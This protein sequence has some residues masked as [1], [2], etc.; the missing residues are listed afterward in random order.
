LKHQHFEA[1]RPICPLCHTRFGQD[2]P[3]RVGLAVRVDRDAVHEGALHC[4]N[5][6]CQCEFPIVDGI[7]L[8]VPQV[9]SYVANNIFHLL[10]RDDLS[11]EVEGMLGDGCGP[12]SALD[13]TRAHLSSYAWD[14]YGEFDSLESPGESRPGSVVRVLD[15]GLSLARAAWTGPVLDA[16][17][18]VGRS[19]FELAR[20]GGG[21]VLGV[22]LNFSMLQ[23]AAGVL[24]RG[25][26]R[27]PRRR[28]GLVYDRREFPVR[29]ER[30]ADIDFW[31]CDATALPFP[32]GTFGAAVSLNVLDC[33]A[34]PLDLL[35]SLSRV[36]R[37]KAPLM[38]STPYDWNGGVTAPEAWIGGHSQRS[39]GYG[40]SEPVLRA[41]LT[42][43]AHPVSV[44]T[45][46]LTAEVD[47]LMWHVRLHD[48]ST[49]T[50]RTH[51][52]VAQACA[53]T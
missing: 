44:G 2:V 48:R 3:L 47:D 27:Y 24:R 36:L 42:P 39:A 40:A 33:V 30:T 8:L 31:A 50:Y 11:E 12:G 18:S 17:C 52:V 9:R 38:L 4:T 6:D 13:A 10:A 15:R 49:M 22:D 14:H 21:L 29:F 20:R 16:G 34:S 53:G 28:V 23:L 37:P 25:T 32:A 43:G 26:V 19:T 1:L 46:R 41:L 7:P 5:P 45:L 51:L 35:R